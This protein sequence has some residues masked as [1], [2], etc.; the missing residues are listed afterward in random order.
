MRQTFVNLFTN[1]KAILWSLLVIGAIL[2][3]VNF[4]VEKV[5]MQE[6]ITW[7]R[8]SKS[9]PQWYAPGWQYDQC[10]KYGIELGI[11]LE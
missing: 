7:E 2:W 4:A 10:E 3:V 6:C 5:E 8:E 11:P 9:Y 1:I